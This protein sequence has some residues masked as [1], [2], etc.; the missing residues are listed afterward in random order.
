MKSIIDWTH[1]KSLVFV[2]SAVTR[3]EVVNNILFTKHVL[4]LDTKK[5]ILVFQP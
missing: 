4:L 3:D 5:N 1:N 2:M